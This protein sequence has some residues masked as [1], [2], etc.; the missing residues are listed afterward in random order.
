MPPRGTTQADPAELE[1][2]ESIA[3]SVRGT[4]QTVEDMTQAFIREAIN[5]GAFPPGERLNI[6][7]IAS[8]LGVSRMPVRA[9]LRQLESEGLIAIHPYR[10]ARV[11]RLSPEEINEIY[12]LRSVIELYLL[13]RAMDAMDTKALDQLQVVVD[14]LKSADDSA[15]VEAR[16]AFYERLFELADRPRAVAMSNQLRSAVGRYLLLQRVNEAP[17][18]QEFV[19]LLRA[20]DQAAASEWLRNH[21]ARVSTRLQQLVA[22]SDNAEQS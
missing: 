9:V 7:R 3:R 10:G 21:L 5:S 1:E 11:T 15:V 20:G 14:E 16:Q 18:H 4:F 17:V 22:E 2:L 19:D 8:L 13:D 12:E 6:D